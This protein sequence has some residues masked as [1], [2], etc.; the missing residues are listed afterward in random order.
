VDNGNESTLK[1][2]IQLTYISN[3]INSNSLL[4]GIHVATQI[5][6]QHAIEPKAEV[7]N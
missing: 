4:E 2:L 6:G 7:Q 1:I 3:S 5:S